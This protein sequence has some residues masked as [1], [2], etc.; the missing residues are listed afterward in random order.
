MEG[1]HEKPKRKESR[2]DIRGKGKRG[3]RTVQA[4]G[5]FGAGA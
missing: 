3:K 4:M 1:E 2:L 5:G